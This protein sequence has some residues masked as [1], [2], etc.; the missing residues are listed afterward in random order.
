MALGT[1]NPRSRCQH[2]PCPNSYKGSFS[3]G[4]PWSLGESRKEA[5]PYL[6]R[7]RS[8]ALMTDS[9]CHLWI[10]LCGIHGHEDFSILTGEG[11]YTKPVFGRLQ[12]W[13]YKTKHRSENIHEL[14]Q[15]MSERGCRMNEPALKGRGNSKIKISV[16]QKTQN[17]SEEDNSRTGGSTHHAYFCKGLIW[18][19]LSTDK[20]K[21]HKTGNSN[22]QM[23]FCCC[24]S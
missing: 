4:P 11:E 17:G 5:L 10:L 21:V 3:L 7:A 13:E 14:E 16:H 1:E 15:R 9:R 22:N 12:I 23:S 24:C 18:D 20:T 19:L 8:P 2:V 6:M